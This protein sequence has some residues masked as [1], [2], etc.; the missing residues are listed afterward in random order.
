MPGIKKSGLFILLLVLFVSAFPVFSAS[1]GTLVLP[2]KLKT[3]AAEAFYGD[4]SVRTVV[5]Q[6]GVTGIGSKAFANSGLREITLP[7]SLTSIAADAF[8]GSALRTVHAEKGTYAYQWM[9]DNGYIAEYRALLI[10]EQRFIWYY[11]EDNPDD[12]C[13]MDDAD[14]RNVGDVRSLAAALGNAAGPHGVYGPDGGAFR[15]TR[16]TNLSRSGIRN[17]IRS[18]FADTRDQDIS[19]FFIATHGLSTGDGDLRTAFTGSISDSADVAA[20]WPNR[21]LSFS[22]LASWLKTYIRGRVL[23]ILQSCGAGSA[24]YAGDAAASGKGTDSASG[25]ERFVTEAVN[26]FSKADPGVTVTLPDDSESHLAPASTGDLRLPKFYV[27]AASAHHEENYGWETEEE[28]TSYN[29]FTS[30]LIEGIGRRD[31]SPADT[32]GSNVLSLQELYL[33]IRHYDIHPFVISGI[34]YYQ[35]VR[36]YP[37]GSTTRLLKLVR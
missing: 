33:Y 34:T 10:G 13:W 27:L 36:C 15:I 28:E 17:A 24:I 3:V 14:Q 6:E 20:Y 2:G 12:G 32:D 31:A 18:A 23:V 7:S 37:M 19:V 25:A 16:K 22:T 1:A 8:E 29:Y 9:R 35:H 4:A 11:N 30:W 26:A 21:Y 5:L